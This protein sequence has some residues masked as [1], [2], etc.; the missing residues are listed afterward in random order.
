MGPGSSHE[1][2]PGLRMYWEQAL[3]RLLVHEVSGESM[4]P[5]LHPK[6]LIYADP[7]GGAELGDL[8]VVAH[9]FRPIRLVKRLAERSPSGRLQVRGD[10]PD[11]FESQDS[12]GFGALRPDALQGRVVLV[13]RKVRAVPAPFKALAEAAPKALRSALAP[14]GSSLR[15]AGAKDPRG[16]E[17]HL[18]V[19]HG[20]DALWLTT[21]SAALSW[22]Q[23]P[24]LT[25]WL[26]S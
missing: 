25:A 2:A 4:F 13:R 7:E 23:A 16:C 10:H 24:W 15:L 21:S 22:L 12:R 1:L 19:A 18:E 8:V 14:D 6:D 5:T 20:S 17:A 3:P 26:G 9:P 11:A